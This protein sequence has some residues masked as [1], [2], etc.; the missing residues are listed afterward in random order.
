M[1]RNTNFAFLNATNSGWDKIQKYFEAN[2]NEKAK[3]IELLDPKT[4]RSNYSLFDLLQEYGTSTLFPEEKVI[5][6]I[7]DIKIQTQISQEKNRRYQ[8]YTALDYLLSTHTY[9]DYFSLDAFTLLNNAKILMKKYKKEKLTS[10]IF[11]LSFFSIDSE[12]IKI[13]NEFDITQESIEN[14]LNRVEKSKAKSIQNK[15]FAK[16]S[17]MVSN[18]KNKITEKINSFSPIFE[19][20]MSWNRPKIEEN[21]LFLID[22]SKELYKIFEKTIEKTLR[23]KTPIITPEILFLNFIDEE[24]LRGGKILKALIKNPIKTTLLRY[25]IVKLIHQNESNLRSLVPKNQHFFAYL[26]KAE[27]SDMEFQKL[28]QTNRL[29]K[30]V[31][32]FRN[33]LISSTVQVD[34]AQLLEEELVTI[35]KLNSTRR[36]SF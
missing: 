1:K 36:Y 9:F 26:L 35:S 11:M 5:E 18:Q 4:N 30:A 31:N 25:Q 28:V 27:L 12:L 15:Y 10:D 6:E 20:Y 23:Y 33:Q 19:P 14:Y 17:S 32:V 13:L 21:D 7:S 22:Y 8:A 34:L 29:T 24:E 2:E 16:L 3:V